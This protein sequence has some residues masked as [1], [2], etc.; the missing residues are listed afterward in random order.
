MAVALAGCCGADRGQGDLASD[1]EV[2]A[3]MAVLPA[4]VTAAFADFAIGAALFGSAG[5]AVRVSWSL[6]LLVVRGIR[7]YLGGGDR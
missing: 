7:R 1:R 4:L 3:M 5:I 2:S 6:G